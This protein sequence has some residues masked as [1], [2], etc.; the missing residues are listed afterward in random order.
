MNNSTRLRELR[1]A[2]AIFPFTPKLDDIRGIDAAGH[3]RL[4]FRP[5][6]EGL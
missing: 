3:L 5:K 2:G 4:R 1:L 6:I